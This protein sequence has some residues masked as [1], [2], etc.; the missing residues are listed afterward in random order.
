ML[1]ST[2]SIRKTDEQGAEQSQKMSNALRVA[3]RHDNFIRVLVN[4]EIRT[5]WR[6]YGIDSGTNDFTIGIIAVKIS[7]LS[8]RLRRSTISDGC[9]LQILRSNR[10]FSFPTNSIP[11]MSNEPPL[12]PQLPS[13]FYAAPNNRTNTTINNGTVV[14]NSFPDQHPLPPTRQFSHFQ[15]Y[16]SVTNDGNSQYPLTSNTFQYRNGPPPICPTAPGSWTTNERPNRSAIQTNGP[17]Q[18]NTFNTDTTKCTNTN[19]IA[20]EEYRCQPCNLSLDSLA[21]W[22]AHRSSHITCTECTFSATPKVI[23][24]HYAAVHGKFSGAGFKTVTIAIPGVRTVQR[25]SICVGNHPDDIQRW[26][27]E[28]HK[29][30][31]RQKRPPSSETTSTL[32]VSESN[33]L[34]AIKVAP[35]SANDSTTSGAVLS[36]LLDGYGSSSSDDDNDTVAKCKA[37]KPSAVTTTVASAVLSLSEMPKA[38]TCQRAIP[39]ESVDSSRGYRTRSCHFY[40]RNGNCRNG[41][42][43][44]FSH[45]RST[46][47]REEQTGSLPFTTPQANAD[48]STTA[49]VRP[50]SAKR[51]KRPEESPVQSTNF[52]K[53]LLANDVKRE[54][55]LTLQLLDFIVESDFLTKE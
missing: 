37:D 44:R 30:F 10:L 45:D 25:F 20:K 13:G 2:G 7:R 5:E 24:G 34:D 11:R 23:N 6:D 4:L 35:R 33:S 16:H 18:Q 17:F 19:S 32:L 49:L 12:D 47:S 42:H 15:S 26:I 3:V 39:S 50:P 38:Q 54:A 52:L 9:R 55:I 28:R 41:D 40:M 36:S 14:V 27:A 43:C 1:Q 8:F 51:Q 48:P 21:A 53:K 31:P 46:Q 22:N 29:R